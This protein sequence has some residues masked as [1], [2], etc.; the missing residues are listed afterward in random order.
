MRLLHVTIV[1]CSSSLDLDLNPAVQTSVVEHGYTPLSVG[2][3]F[4]VFYLP[5]DA[6]LRS[7]YPERQIESVSTV[8][9]GIQ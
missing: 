8:S 3:L 9:G 5:P 1:I 4:G 2:V 6:L 7:F